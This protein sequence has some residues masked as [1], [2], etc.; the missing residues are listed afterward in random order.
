MVIITVD[1]DSVD[2]MVV[3]IGASVVVSTTVTG[4]TVSIVAR[5]VVVLVVVFHEVVV[6][7]WQFS[8]LR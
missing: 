1:P 6:E 8:H 7:V 4:T 2:V 3:T 5:Y